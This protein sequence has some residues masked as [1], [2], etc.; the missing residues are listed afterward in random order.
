MMLGIVVALGSGLFFLLFKKGDP[1]QTVKALTVRI[2][3]SLILFAFIVVAFSLGWVKPHTLFP[4]A[5]IQTQIETTTPHPQSANTMP[6]LQNQNGAA[7]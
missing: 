6:P 3:L 2:G 4:T 5:R 1:A 7:D